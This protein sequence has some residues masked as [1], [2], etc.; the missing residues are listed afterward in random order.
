MEVRQGVFYGVGVGPGD[1][2]LLTTKALR[3]LERCSVIAAPRTKSGEMLALDIVRQAM[4]L[5]GK[6]ILPLEFTMSRDPAVLRA[7][8]L[9][10]S[11]TIAARLSAGQDVAMLNLGDVSIYATFGYLMDMLTGEG[12]KAVMVPGVPSFCAVAARLGASLT[13]VSS[14]LHILPGGSS[15]LAEQLDLP[16]TKVL[17]KSGRQLPQAAE[18][19]RQKGLLEKAAMVRDC[20][21]PTEQVCRDLTRLPEETGYFATVIVKE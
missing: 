21:L 9:R 19:L 3:T 15:S 8:R 11:E 4:P 10:A 17:M 16:G 20:G 7:S 2:E 18:V 1:P 14:P 5:E 12:Y 6:T 13:T